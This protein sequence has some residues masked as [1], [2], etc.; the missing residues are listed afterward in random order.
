[1]HRLRLLHAL[2][3]VRSTD[4]VS[5]RQST[6][7]FGFSPP[8]KTIISSDGAM[9]WQAPLSGSRAIPVLTQGNNSALGIGALRARTDPHAFSKAK[10]ELITD[11]LPTGTGIASAPA[12]PSPIP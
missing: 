6:A 9:A 5:A 11:D 4:L 3:F 7:N 10:S 8:L 12:P 1:M 2:P